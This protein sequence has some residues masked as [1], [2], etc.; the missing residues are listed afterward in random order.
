[1][2]EVFDWSF[3]KVVEVSASDSPTPGGGSVS[4]LVASLGVAMTAMVCNLTIGKEKFKDVEPQAIEIRDEANEI[5]KKLEK[6]V[7]ADIAE[8]GN[9]MSV[10]KLPK[11]TDEE[12]AKRTEL[13]QKALKSA[14]DTPL[15]IARTCLQAL[16]ITEKLSKIGNT[17]AISD[18]GVAAYVAEAALNAVLL[19][20]DINI[21]M[22]KDQ[23]YVQNVMAEKEKLVAEAKKLKDLAVATVQERMK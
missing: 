20:C 9:F 2:S 6:L 17:M 18:A 3:R 1:M 19:S 14:T 10:L 4:A 13:M 5:I 22:I 11:N 15:E 12:K 16:V 21:P 8:F 7:A 23:D